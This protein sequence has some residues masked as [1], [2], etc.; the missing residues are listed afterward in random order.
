[1]VQVIQC[2]CGTVLRAPDR[3]AVIALAQQHANEV[4]GLELTRE[5][6]LAM[7]HPEDIDQH[8]GQGKTPV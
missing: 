1:M 7:T 4:H 8:N 6:A 2:S 3:E 5:Q